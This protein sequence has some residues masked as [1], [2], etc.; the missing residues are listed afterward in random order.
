MAAPKHDQL[1]RELL[2]A[3]RALPGAK[4]VRKSGYDR[5]V[6]S[7][8]TL[9]YVNRARQPRVDV[10]QDDGYAKHKVAT[11]DDIAAVVAV[12]DGIDR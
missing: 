8:K 2:E 9:A 3:I 6:R 5:V 12:I 10:R 1:L 11:T 7:G 4:V